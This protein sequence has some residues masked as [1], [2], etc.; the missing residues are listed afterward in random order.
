MLKPQDSQRTK[1]SWIRENQ[2]QFRTGRLKKE[3]TNRNREEWRRDLHRLLNQ[4]SFHMYFVFRVRNGV[5]EACWYGFWADPNRARVRVLEK[6]RE[7]QENGEEDGTREERMRV[8]RFFCFYISA[9]TG[10]GSNRP[11]PSVLSTF[12]SRFVLIRINPTPLKHQ[13][14]SGSVWDGYRPLSVGLGRFL[15]FFF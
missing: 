8:N 5:I 9:W 12:R 3:R 15:V 2:Q 10:S 11:M 6:T 1:T 7:E 13:V 4:Q 14:W